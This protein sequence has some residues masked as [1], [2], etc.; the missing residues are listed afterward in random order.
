[1][2]RSISFRKLFA[3]LFVVTC[4]SVAAIAQ[5]AP[6]KSDKDKARDEAFIKADIDGNAAFA[7]KDYESAIKIYKA[8]YANDSSH[9]AAPLALMK[10][11]AVHI[12][13][14]TESYNKG[15][16]AKDAALTEAGKAD[17]REAAFMA[18][19]AFIGA[20]THKYVDGGLAQIMAIRVLALRLVAIKV[21][22]N[23]APAAVAAY[24]E[25]LI[26]ETDSTKL[27]QARLELGKLLFDTGDAARARAAY[28]KAWIASPRN[29]DALFGLG[30]TL[31]F[32]AAES[33]DKVALQKAANL[34]NSFLGL[35]SANDSRR[36]EA[37]YILDEIKK[38][39]NIVPK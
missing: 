14:G 26:T 22:I 27:L 31:Y 30:S 28:E 17:L 21:D 32:S 6:V 5:T 7:N 29:V 1:M 36:N 33:G 23:R 19:R 35:A 8:A 2:E 13:R 24:D 34:L 25:Y 38:S 15:V 9:A 37:N 20:K 12:Q 18:E 10:V 39:Y 4:I 16:A 3:S 11:A